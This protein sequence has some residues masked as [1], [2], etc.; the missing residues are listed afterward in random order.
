MNKD[1]INSLKITHIINATNHIPNIHE[2][3]GNLDSY[4]GIKYLTIPV[5]DNDT[6]KIGPYFKDA[7][8]FVENALSEGLMENG[9]LMENDTSKESICCT[10]EK[11]NN[12]FKKAEILHKAFKNSY[13]HTKNSNRILIHCSLGV[14]RSSTI[15]IMY[16]MKKFSICYEEVSYHYNLLGL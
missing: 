12:L 1:V 13:Y 2:K 6:N 15:A 14:S 11:S 4:K 16:I 10:L 8:S 5:E 3:I 9:D 7:Y